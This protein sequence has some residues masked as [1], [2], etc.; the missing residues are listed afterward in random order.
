LHLLAASGLLRRGVAGNFL[1]LRSFLS[2]LSR[3]FFSAFYPVFPF[4]NPC[5]TSVRARR[6][7]APG[8]GSKKGTR[9]AEIA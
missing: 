8:G 7:P 9:A 5:A 4:K 6:S 3:C 2:S 1:I